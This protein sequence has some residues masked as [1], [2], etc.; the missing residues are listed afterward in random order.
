MSGWDTIIVGG[1]SAGCVLAEALSRDPDHRVMLIESGRRDHSPWIHIPGTFFKVMQGGIDSILYRSEAEQGLDG[2]ACLVPQGH[3]LGGGSSVNAMLYVRGQPQDYDGW[4]AAGCAGWDWG[5]V[6]PVFKQMEGNTALDG[7]LHGTAG[8]LTVSAPRHRHRL[9]RAFVAAGVQA[10]LPEN[11]DFN[12]YEQEGVG[13]YQTTTRDGRRCSAA[14]AFLRPAMKRTNLTILTGARV[15]RVMLENGR[16]CGVR[17][18]DGRQIDATR[19]VILTAG[20]LA[21]PLILMRSG[22]GPA[23]ELSRHGIPVLFDRRGVGGNYQ[24]HMAVPVEV[25]TN[26]PISTY[27]QDRGLRG[28]R[29]LASYLLARRGLMASN[30]V[31]AGGFASVGGGDRPD[32]Q[33]HV[34]PGFAG[35]P[36][37]PPLPGHGF[38]ASVCVLRPHSRGSVTLRG[39]DPALPGL[40]RAGVLSHPEDMALSLRGL[41]LLLDI[42]DQPALRDVLGKRHLPVAGNETDAA[43]TTHIRAQAKT[44]YHPAGTARMGDAADPDA[45][46]ESQLRVIGVHN[47]RVADASVMPNLVSGNTNAP[48]MM[49]AARAAD[50]VVMG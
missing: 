30:I 50:F 20:A 36:G 12:G 31:E 11:P 14:V 32:V 22:I 35:A 44:V 37:I 4:E 48:T 18:T 10:G 9:T 43:L 25:E 40:F 3:V 2:R 24:D 5:N 21:T 23:A 45:V 49:I 17:L 42:L 38:S 34:L 8:P 13:F 46:C 16:A 15:D 19:E 28:A 6:L 33:F 7:P 27:G 1:G 29:N 39:S 26:Q 41:R 47:L